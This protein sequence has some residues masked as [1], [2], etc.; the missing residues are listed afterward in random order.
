MKKLFPGIAMIIV[1]LL[2]VTGC[3]TDNKTLLTDGVWKFSNMT[4]DSEDETIIGLIT[5]GKAILTDGTLE[6]KA[7]ETYILSAPL[8][9]ESQTG[10]WSLIVDDQLIMDSDGDLVSTSNI[11]T[12]SKSELKYIETLVDT[13][14]N[15]YSVTTSW[16][17]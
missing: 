10:T 7:D 5:L 2:L 12:L 4:T 14:M 3:E 11:E 17:K 16:S 1:T 15:S 9:Q 13:E 6:F 8:L